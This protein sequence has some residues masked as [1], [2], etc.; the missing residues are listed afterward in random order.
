MSQSD[1]FNE[2]LEAITNHLATALNQHCQDVQSHPGRFTE[3]ELARLLT[4]KKAVRVAIENTPA[5]TVSGQGIQQA[6]LLIAAFVICSDTKDAPR[7]K[8][9]LKITEAILELLPFNRFGTENLRPLE[10]K[11]IT[12][13]NLYSGE[14][15]RKG[16]ALWG[17]SWEQT[18]EKKS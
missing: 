3:A 11:T 18:V 13:E 4:A 9:V 17:I 8:S 16:I 2:S 10:P 5:V 1:L 7:H 12:A 15:D 6:R 14:V